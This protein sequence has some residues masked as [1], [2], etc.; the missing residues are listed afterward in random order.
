VSGLT[1]GIHVRG[2]FAYSLLILCPATMRLATHL[3]ALLPEVEFHFLKST[4]FPG[5]P[6]IGRV[7]NLPT[8]NSKSDLRIS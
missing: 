5:I 2:A 7:G 8:Q 3:G 1:G 4:K 6:G